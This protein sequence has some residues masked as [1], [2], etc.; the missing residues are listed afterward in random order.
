MSSVMKKATMGNLIRRYYKGDAHIHFSH[1][2]SP[3]F[4]SWKK[5]FEEKTVPEIYEKLGFEFMVLVLHSSDPARPSILSSS[6]PLSRKL[7]RQARYV[8]RYC[9]SRKPPSCHFLSGAE[10]NIM[11]DTKGK[12]VLDVPQSVLS[13]LDIVVASRHA[14]VDRQGRP[15]RALEK[16]P[17]R[18][19]ES[20][21]AAI[22]NP[23]VRIIGHPDRYTRRDGAV[24]RAYW[25]SYWR[26]WPDILAAMKKHRVAFE[27]NLS[28]PPEERIMRMALGCGVSFFISSDVHYV[29]NFRFVELAREY[30]GDITADAP[31]RMKRALRKVTTEWAKKD[32]MSK[33]QHHTAFQLLFQLAYW[34]WYLHRHQVAPRRV[35]NSSYRNVQQFIKKR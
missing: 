5:L 29:E 20:L 19:R 23:Y 28:S 6:A 10:V 12:P 21:L 26:I 11:Y 13:Q 16:D 4:R 25:Q 35:I 33:E 31:L 22:R 1:I 8:K 3:H 30:C 27:I 34:T 14:I 24:S 2:F 9:R 7:V 18:I 32:K 17:A 15:D